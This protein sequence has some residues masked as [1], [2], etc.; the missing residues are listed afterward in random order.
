MKKLREA[1]N[2]REH[3]ARGR[4]AQASCR[5]EAVL[6]DQT[7]GRMKACASKPVAS[8]DHTNCEGGP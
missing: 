2:R 4:R 5:V 6:D 3:G 7:I 8:G 1:G